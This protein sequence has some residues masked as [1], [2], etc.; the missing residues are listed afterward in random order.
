MAAS[1]NFPDIKPSSRKYTPGEYPQTEF[2]A[3]NGAKTVLRYGNKRVDAK[4]TL[5]FTNISDTKANELLE[6]YYEINADYD[7]AYFT[8]SDAFVCKIHR[9]ITVCP[10]KIQ[11]V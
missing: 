7:Y 1:R 2:I 6:F 4:L 10:K 8:F 9:Y 11:M 5:G 3:Q